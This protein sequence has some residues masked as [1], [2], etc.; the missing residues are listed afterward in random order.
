MRFRWWLPVECLSPP[1]RRTIL[2]SSGLGHAIARERRQRQ[3]RLPLRSACVLRRFRLQPATSYL[4]LLFEN[5]ARSGFMVVRSLAQ[6]SAT[7][8]ACMHMRAPYTASYIARYAEVFSS[9]HMHAYVWHWMAS[10]SAGWPVARVN[11]YRAHHP[12][13]QHCKFAQDTRPVDII[14]PGH[15]RGRRQEPP[16]RQH[17]TVWSDSKT[18]AAAGSPCGQSGKWTCC[19]NPRPLRSIAAKV[20]KITK[21]KLCRND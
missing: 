12:L 19:R 1:R 13:F 8:M 15:E 17:T 21:Q 4:H 9:I 5:Q 10:T 6:H 18:V 3:V 7:L 16:I 20:P 14:M 2:A 11:Y